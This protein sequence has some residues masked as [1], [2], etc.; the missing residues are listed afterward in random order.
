MTMA[1]IQ[2]LDKEKI[3]REVI[4]HPLSFMGLQSICLF[5]LVWGFV[6]LWLINSPY[7]NGIENFFHG[8]VWP[9]TI[10]AIV[11]WW[12][13]LL[14]GGAIASLLAIRWR[15]FFTYLGILAIG[16]AL[17]YWRE[18]QGAY[19][20]FIPIYSIIVSIIGFVCVDIYRRSHHYFITN[21]RLIFRG[22]ILKKR[23]RTLRYDKITD[24]EGSQGIFGRIFGFGTIIP[25][26]QSGFGLGSDSS[27]AAGG[28]EVK[29]TKRAGVIGIAGG[30]KEVK[31]PRTRSYYELH[32]AHPYREVKGL[33]EGL[34]QSSTIA[35]YQKEQVDL[36]K[37]MLELLK[38]QEQ[39]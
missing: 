35:P 20:W 25:I 4:P 14:V 26:T 32:G 5:I 19:N 12:V 15:I 8:A 3:E 34:V 10:M 31:T 38:R 36:Q 28:I 7:W 2:L 27:F 22:G 6:L 30:G 29:P 1:A 18:W 39:E 13:V 37:E 16:T 24:V 9:S 21:L 33:L 17:M 23:E 11:I